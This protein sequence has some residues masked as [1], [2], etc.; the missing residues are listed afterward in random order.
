MFFFIFW[1]RVTHRPTAQ[2]IFN[3][4]AQL[5]HPADRFFFLKGVV[6]VY[7]QQQLRDQA[8]QNLDH[9]AVRTTGDQMVNFQMSFPP[10]KKVLDVPA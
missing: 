4:G 2:F 8:G 6:A 3:L 5:P 10:G 7:G 9:Q 1:V